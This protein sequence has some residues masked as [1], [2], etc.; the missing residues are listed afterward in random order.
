LFAIVGGG[1]VIGG[2]REAMTQAEVQSELQRW[3]LEQLVPE[4]ARPQD[5]V[6]SNDD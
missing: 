6:P 2:I 4:S 5:V 3:H 1:L